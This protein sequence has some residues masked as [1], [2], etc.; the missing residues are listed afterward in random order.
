MDFGLFY[1]CQGRGVPHDQADVGARP[2]PHVPAGG[3]LVDPH[4]AGLE[5]EPAAERHGVAGI[6][7]QVHHHLFQLPAID[8]DRDRGGG[9]FRLDCHRRAEQQ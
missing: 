9:Q 3:L 5:A 7:R 6:D 1:Y 2:E 4:V 8:A